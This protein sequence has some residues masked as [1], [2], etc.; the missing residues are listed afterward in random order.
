MGF[1]RAIFQKSEKRLRRVVTHA[2]LAI[3]V[4]VAV[5]FSFLFGLP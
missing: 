5:G 1:L 3:L 2:I 4:I